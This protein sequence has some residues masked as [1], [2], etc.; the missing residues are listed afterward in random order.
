MS[1]MQSSYISA[2]QQ[3]NLEIAMSQGEQ[4]V[5]NHGTVGMGAETVISITL[6]QT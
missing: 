4:L 2:N 6:L 1:F 5:E 3:E